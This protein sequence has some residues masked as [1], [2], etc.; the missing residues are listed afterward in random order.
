MTNDTSTIAGALQEV[1]DRLEA[2]L[3]AK[4]VTAT[5]DASTGILGLVDEIQNITGGG[6]GVPCYKVEFT[7]RSMTYGDWNFSTNSQEALLEVYLQYQYEAF[8]GAVTITDGTNTYTATTNANGYGTVIVPI[9]ENST[10]FTASYINTTDTL[11]VTKSTYLFKDSCAN[12]SGLSSYGTYEQIY[13]SSSGNPSC[14]LSFDSNNNCYEI[15][16][17][18][19]GTSYYS[20]IPITDTNVV[21]K[22]NYVA[23]IEIK[24]VGSGTTNECGLYVDNS[25]DTSSYG[26]GSTIYSGGDKHYGK[27]CKIDSV[28]TSNNVSVDMDRNVWYTLELKVTD[29]RFDV[30]L[31]DSNHNLLNEFGYAQTVSNK[32]LGIMQKGGGVAATSNLIRN[33]K[34]RSIA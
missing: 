20:M 24:Q 14:V 17:T 18:N 32:K 19:T 22:T 34:I 1:I 6:S 5:Y 28:S 8:E 30:Y 10:T 2:N 29:T 12:S 31:Y 25:N 3:A 9:T 21:G 27:R 7:S 33:I 13:K 16:S 23:S 26:Y 4:G 15:H 11:T